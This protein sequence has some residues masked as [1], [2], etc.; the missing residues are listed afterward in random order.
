MFQASR[1]FTSLTSVLLACL[2][3]APALG[4]GS[5]PWPPVTPV[6]PGG[7][8]GPSVPVVALDPVYVDLELLLLVDVSDSVDEQEYALQVGGYIEAFG[9]PEIR[10]ALLSLEGVAVKMLLWSSTQQRWS[11]SWV[12]IQAESDCEDLI[13]HMT[14]L[15]VSRP[16]SHNTVMSEAIRS[17]LWELSHNAF[18]SPRQVIDVSG[19][20]ICDNFLYYKDA[21]PDAVPNID[22]GPV[23]WDDVKTRRLSTT[24]INGISVGNE[25]GLAQWYASEVAQGEGSF[26]MHANNFADF[27]AGIKRKLI[28]EITAI[29]VSYD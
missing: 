17:G 19:D 12:H 10:E 24:T 1:R 25:P 11:T 5:E 13:N 23:K 4:G 16:F 3:A 15:S 6:S 14:Y 2:F 27:S 18:E 26:S 8:G 20:G 29:P 28:H 22:Y 9:D 7:G 21:E